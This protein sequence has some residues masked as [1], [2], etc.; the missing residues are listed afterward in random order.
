MFVAQFWYVSGVCDWLIAYYS[1]SSSSNNVRIPNV[2]Q[3][4]ELKLR[5]CTKNPEG[6]GFHSWWG[7]W[8]FS[9][10]RSFRPHYGRGVKESD[11]KRN[12]YQGYLLG[13]CGVWCVGLATL[14]FSCTDYLENLGA[15]SSWSPNDLSRPVMGELLFYLPNIH[16]HSYDF[17]CL[18]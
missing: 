2:D 1:Y 13:G 11:P 8:D 6:R 15:S 14:P 16:A 9:C 7:H 18:S 17:N 3:I 5:H 12:G 10:T 4:F